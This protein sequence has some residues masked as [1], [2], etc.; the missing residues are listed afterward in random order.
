MLSLFSSAPL[1]HHLPIPSFYNPRQNGRRW[2]TFDLFLFRTP[3]AG[4]TYSSQEGSEDHVKNPDVKET[5]Q[6]E[7]SVCYDKIFHSL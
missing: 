6:Y 5:L 1:L 7:Q 4:M 2:N 3:G